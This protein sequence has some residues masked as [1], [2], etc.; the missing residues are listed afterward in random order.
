MSFRIVR[1]IATAVAG[2]GAAACVATDAPSAMTGLDARLAQYAEVTLSTD[3]SLLTPK[4]LKMIPVLIGAARAMDPIFRNELYPA[5]DSLMKATSDPVTRKYIE[6]NVGPW[7]R[8]ANDTPFI[9][10]VGPKPPAANFYP[11]DMTRE[12][13]ERAV[14]E[15]PPAH[16]DSLKDLYTLVRRDSKGRLTAEPYHIAYKGWHEAAASKLR[17][18]AALA[19]DA[20]LKRYLNARAEALLSDNY[21]Q[22]DIAWM[23]MKANTLDIVIGPIEVYEDGLFGYKASHEAYVLVKD[24]AW[25]DRLARFAAFLPALQRGL[26]VPGA[27]KTERPGTDSDLNAYDV[28]Y[29]G[30]A[31][32]IGGKTIAINLPNDEEVQLRKG[33]R[34][35]QLKNV[36]REKF[37]RI[38][39]PIANELIVPEQAEMIQFD[40]FFENTMFHEVAHGLGIKNTLNGRGSVRA[41][42]KERYSALEEGKAD[43]LGLYMVQSLVKSGNLP[44]EDVRQNYV[45]FLAS[46]FRSTRF[47]AADAHGRANIAAFNFLQEQGA[48]PRD[49]TTGRYAVDFTKMEAGMNALVT[50]IITMQGDGD[51]AAAGE[52]QQKYGSISPTLQQ[53]LARLNAKAIP[54]DLRFRQ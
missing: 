31:A 38:L 5:Y 9:A 37:D 19:E 46:L 15:G 12:E 32:N 52:F 48:F 23:D 34:R 40:A 26:P 42:L 45:D 1:P 7:D 24:K 41:A 47:G 22:S 50:K 14:A 49:S 13:F 36:I 51:Y 33:T 21:R 25:S 30:G 4:E 54:V 43:I 3:T 53:D 11:R 6:V 39:L 2:L 8:L 27:Y 17:E 18:A 10:G 20:G 35:L 16:A 28:L 29:Y 44:G